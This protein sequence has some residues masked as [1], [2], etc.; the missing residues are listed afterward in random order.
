MCPK[1]SCPKGTRPKRNGEIQ[2]GDKCS[3]V[4][5]ECVPGNSISYFL[6]DTSQIFLSEGK[7]FVYTRGSSGFCLSRC[8]TSHVSPFAKRKF[9]KLAK[10]LTTMYMQSYNVVSRQFCIGCKYL[11]QVIVPLIRIVLFQCSQL[12]ALH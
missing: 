1:I 6:G 12:L 10:F 11:N 3:C 8:L 7:R 4:I 2:L 9:A 5:Q